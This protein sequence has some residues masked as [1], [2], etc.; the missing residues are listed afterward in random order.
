MIPY[1]RPRGSDF[2]ILSQAKLLENHTFHSGTYMYVYENTP[3]GGPP[4]PPLA[5]HLRR[6]T[7][8]LGMF[9]EFSVSNK[10]NKFTICRL[11]LSIFLGLVHLVL[12][13]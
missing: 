13:L 12:I 6:C 4:P 11:K 8:R 2:C 7:A 5:W 9:S 3:G 1:S 10:V